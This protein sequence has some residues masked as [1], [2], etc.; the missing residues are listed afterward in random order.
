MTLEEIKEAVNS[1]K[2]VFWKH[3]GYEVTK[4]CINQWFIGCT[5]NNHKIGLTWVDNVT[6]NGKEED[7]FIQ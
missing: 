5:F 7:F 3:E 6:L 2:K 4:D 1:G